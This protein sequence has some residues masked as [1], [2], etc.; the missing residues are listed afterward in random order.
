ML[1]DN[2]GK[3]VADLINCVRKQVVVVKKVN[4]TNWKIPRIKK[5][6]SP[7]NKREGG[8]NANRVT[9]QASEL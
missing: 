8:S 6:F 7:Y 9:K 2:I 1:D 5:C 4:S 3:Q